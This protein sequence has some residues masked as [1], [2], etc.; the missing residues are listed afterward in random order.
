MLELTLF[1]P[2]IAAALFVLVAGLIPNILIVG[3][4]GSGK[5]VG[6]ATGSKSAPAWS[7]GGDSSHP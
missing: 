2:L 1:A 5:S 6:A 4:P 7:P 3:E